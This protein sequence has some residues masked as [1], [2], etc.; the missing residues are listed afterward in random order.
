MIGKELSLFATPGAFSYGALEK[1]LGA[2]FGVDDAT[3]QGALRGRIKH[4]QR[5]GLPGLKAGKGARVEYSVEQA[6]QWLLALLLSEAGVDPVAGV[7]LMREHWAKFLPW[8]KRAQDLKKVR[9]DSGA[10]VFLTVRPHLM[11]APEISFAYRRH[12][13]RDADEGLYTRNLTDA[14]NTFHDNLHWD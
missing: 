4:L 8:C 12:L 13:T 5:L 1:A 3:Q 6:T 11:G 2:V 10:H 7:R 9:T 14:L